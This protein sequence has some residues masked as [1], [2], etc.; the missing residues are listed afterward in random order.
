MSETEL[1]IAIFGAVAGYFVVTRLMR[2]RTPQ[3]P[4]A[5]PLPASMDVADGSIIG[6]A[7]Q[8]TPPPGHAM[9]HHA[10]GSFEVTTTPQS[11]AQEHAG[12]T[13]ARM[14]L[15]KTFS[16]DLAG[17]GKGQML[18]AL[19]KTRGSAAYAAIEHVTGT[20]HGR[21]GSFVFQ[22]TGS[23]DRGEQQLTISVVPDSGT[24]ELSGI[25]GKFMIVIRDNQHFYEFD[26]S[27]PA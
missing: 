22:H 3:P 4:P 26:Y 23:M 14:L 27:L 25:T 8:P 18:T 5:P 12:A 17:T 10:T 2:D 13:L 24:Q 7:I 20:L 6:S 15:D 9:N 16:G 11:D 19:T 21:S 1:I